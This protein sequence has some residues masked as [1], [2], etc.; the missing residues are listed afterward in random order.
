MIINIRGTSGSGKSTVVYELM[1]EF[2]ESQMKF[3]GKTEAHCIQT[4]WGKVYAIG[5][6]ETA[7][8]GCDG[9]PTQD[10]VCRLVRKYSKKGHVIE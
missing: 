6:Y 4:K 9:V 1:E 10:E 7:C 8:G 2:G 3:K 5:R